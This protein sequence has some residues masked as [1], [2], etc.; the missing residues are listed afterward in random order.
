MMKLILVAAGA[1]VAGYAAKSVV[2]KL[3]RDDGESDDRFYSDEDLAA[4]DKYLKPL[5]VDVYGSE[6]DCDVQD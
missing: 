3:R 1:A 6:E 4:L 2:D 5:G